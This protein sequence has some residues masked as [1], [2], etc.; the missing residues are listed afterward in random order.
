MSAST[1]LPR[2]TFEGRR[3]LHARRLNMLASDTGRADGIQE[4][5]LNVVRVHG[6]VVPGAH[7]ASKVGKISA[8]NGCE[9]A[10]W[11]YRANEVQA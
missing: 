10:S 7:A 9:M 5:P 2:I 6:G 3:A 11:P 4:P 8:D 1:K